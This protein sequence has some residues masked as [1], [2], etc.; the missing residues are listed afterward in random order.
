[1][2]PIAFA[3]SFN[4]FGFLMHV[5]VFQSYI[6]TSK[7]TCWLFI[8][9]LQCSYASSQNMGITTTKIDTPIRLCNMGEIAYQSEYFRTVVACFT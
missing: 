6:L 5:L 4:E 9:G 8:F 1:M 7:I 2:S 3:Y